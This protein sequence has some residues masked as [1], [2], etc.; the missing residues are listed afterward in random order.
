M[1]LFAKNIIGIAGVLIS[2]VLLADVTIYRGIDRTD[3]A[4]PLL[5]P[6]QFIYNGAIPG[7]STFDTT[8]GAPE[9][10]PCLYLYVVSGLPDRGGNPPVAGDSGSVSTLP[11]G[12]VAVFDNT[13]P[14][15]WSIRPPAGVSNNQAAKVT[16]ESAKYYR[17][18]VI[19]GTSIC[20]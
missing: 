7:M 18:N 11:D 4:E 20:G 6:D 8:D 17:N 13:P 3:G 15:H 9:S 16:S 19:S 1:R 12:Y 10:K 2:T 14:G 5:G